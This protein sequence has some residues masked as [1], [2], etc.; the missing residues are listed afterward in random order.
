M[1]GQHQRLWT[2][3]CPE[4]LANFYRECVLGDQEAWEFVLAYHAQAHRVDDLVD[5]ALAKVADR[6]EW[7]AEVLRVTRQEQVLWAMPFYRRHEQALHMATCLARSVYGNSAEW[8]HT[9]DEGLRVM[10]DTLRF[11]GN[12][13]IEGCALLVGGYE[14]QR[15]VSKLLWA[16]SYKGHRGEGH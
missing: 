16:M 5:E 2:L 11:A 9:T 6:R 3:E 4:P 10:G 14:H 7:A 12:L 15:A 1:T 8:E 13:V